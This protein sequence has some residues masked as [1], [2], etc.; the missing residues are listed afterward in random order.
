MLLEVDTYS[1]FNKTVFQPEV[2]DIVP[3]PWDQKLFA[4]QLALPRYRSVLRMQQ[5]LET[6][7]ETR[8]MLSVIDTEFYSEGYHTWLIKT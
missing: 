2:P 6:L 5:G 7:Q 3:E 1:F 4:Q 8:E